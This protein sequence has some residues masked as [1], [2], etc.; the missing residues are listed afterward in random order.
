MNHLWTTDLV[1]LCDSYISYAYCKLTHDKDNNDGEENNDCYHYDVDSN[2]FDGNDN[3]N[4]NKNDI[5]M[6]IIVK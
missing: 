1:S 3:K 2:D 5:I 6:T 4:D